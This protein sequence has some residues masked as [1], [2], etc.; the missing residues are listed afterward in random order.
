MKRTQDSNA[1]NARKDEEMKEKTGH[2]AHVSEKFC[3]YTTWK[4][5]ENAILRGGGHP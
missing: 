2:A 5:N 3:R 1:S 4:V